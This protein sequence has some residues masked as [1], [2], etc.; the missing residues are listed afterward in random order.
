M[1]LEDLCRADVP[2][3][4]PETSVAEIARLM[5]DRHVGAVPILEGRRPVGI[6][7]D[8]DIAVRVVAWGRPFDGPAGQIMS[9]DPVCAPVGSGLADAAQIMREHGVRRLPVVDASGDLVGLVALD[10]LLAL[11]GEELASLAGAI[12]HERA[13]EWRELDEEAPESKENAA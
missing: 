1:A 8:R 2:T 10:D 9:P 11:F 13:R 7:T 6:V 5:R 3:A 4:T 12:G